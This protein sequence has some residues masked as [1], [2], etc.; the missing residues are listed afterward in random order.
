MLCPYCHHSDGLH[1][2]PSPDGRAADGRLLAA[3]YEAGKCHAA[4]P[5]FCACPG[6]YPGT[7]ELERVAA[8]IAAR[9]ERNQLAE[10]PFAL[11]APVSQRRQ[12]QGDLF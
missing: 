4:G 5:D 8:T 12:K 9:A 6:W 1:S 3:D 10:V 11:A 7:T 2:R